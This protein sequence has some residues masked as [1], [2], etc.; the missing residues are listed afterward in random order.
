MSKGK[1]EGKYFTSLYKTLYEFN[2]NPIKAAGF[3]GGKYGQTISDAVGSGQTLA[4]LT[5]DQQIYM[6][7]VMKNILYPKSRGLEEESGSTPNLKFLEDLPKE[8]KDSLKQSARSLLESYVQE[9]DS[10]SNSSTTQATTTSIS[11]TSSIEKSSSSSSSSSTSELQ[12]TTSALSTTAWLLG[13]DPIDEESTSPT[14]TTSSTVKALTTS[15]S[16]TLLFS[17]LDPLVSTTEGTST[18]LTGQNL[19]TDTE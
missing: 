7:E 12:T 6:L 14:V 15:R 9:Q 5:E 11:T 4:G 17:P 10:S 1:E 2:T 8:F 3:K 13:G 18:E 16:S 19:T